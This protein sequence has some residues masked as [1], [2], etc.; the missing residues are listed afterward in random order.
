MLASKYSVVLHI[1]HGPSL[2]NEA[3]LTQS[4][5]CGF[6]MVSGGDSLQRKLKENWA[7]KVFSNK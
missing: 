1:G 5:A 3:D 7:K 4:L 2:F 6:G